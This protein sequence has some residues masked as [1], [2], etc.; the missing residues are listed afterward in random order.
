[1][2]LQADDRQAL[3]DGRLDDTVRRSL[4]NG[5]F[6][7][8]TEK[9]NLLF[10]RDLR[11]EPNLGDLQTRGY[12]SDGLIMDGI[13]TKALPVQI[14]KQKYPEH[15]RYRDTS[16]EYALLVVILVMQFLIQAA[17]EEDI[18]HLKAAA[19]AQDGFLPQLRLSAG[20]LSDKHP[21]GRPRYRSPRF[22]SPEPGVDAC[23]AARQQYCI[24]FVKIRRIIRDKGF[25]ALIPQLLQ[26]TLVRNDTDLV[27]PQS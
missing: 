12:C 10:L 7:A 26:R 20:F 15:R 8:E 21:G 19:Y 13:C 18:D 23:P 16:P 9:M 27:L 22:F 5:A 3:V 2:P 11:A 25:C 24:A 1:M 14:V 4:C 17:A 6:L